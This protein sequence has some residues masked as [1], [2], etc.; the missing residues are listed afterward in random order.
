MQFFPL[1]EG[2]QKLSLDLHINRVTFAL[3]YLAQ[4]APQLHGVSGF[5]VHIIIRTGGW[6]LFGHLN[7]RLGENAELRSY[8]LAAE[9][10]KS[11]VTDKPTVARFFLR[12]AESEITLTRRQHSLSNVNCRANVLSS[13]GKE[14][15]NLLACL[16]TR[17]ST[18]DSWVLT[19]RFCGLCFETDV[20]YQID[21]LVSVSCKTTQ[22]S[23]S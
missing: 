11:N 17:F 18:V 23:L 15:L 14:L 8:A 10:P 22:L 21:K 6:T 20:E 4:N 16:A 7:P 13:D 1:K 12:L 19:S 2:T 5:W 9:L 3:R